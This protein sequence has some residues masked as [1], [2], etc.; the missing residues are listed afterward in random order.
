MRQGV[1]EDAWL[2]AV[3]FRQTRPRRR[4]GAY[5][6]K[7]E[8]VAPEDFFARVPRLRGIETRVAA[9]VG[10]GAL[11]APLAFEL[12]RAQLGELR[13]L[14]HDLVE[15]G[16]IV[17]W[18]IGA[19]A[20]GSAKTA[21]VEGTIKSQYPRT[22]CLSIAH[23]VGTAPDGTV[24]ENDFDVLERLLEDAHVVI[25]ATAEIAIQQLIGDLARERALPQVY[26]WGTEG[27]YG[28]VVARSVPGETGCW[29]C[30]QLAIEDGS[31]VAPPREATGT[32]Q[33]RGCGT[34]TFT[35]E[36]F[37]LLPLVAQAARV[38]TSLLL[39]ML[40]VGGDVFVMAL[41]DG[42][43]PAPAPRWTTYPLE[44]HP[45]CPVCA[46]DDA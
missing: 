38:T 33:P 24:H 18:P 9:L 7:G 14:D 25:D 46:S 23:Q 10:L 39:G 45:R 30:L 21:M 40:P 27:A 36:S 31:I 35:G 20:I 17:R 5:L 6:T 1:W 43:D 22:T 8:P 32:T 19:S 4:S 16:T 11:G 2:F 34:P 37:N 3:R 12:A 42:D 44:R 15:A 28:G 26:L 41:R 13:V 29:F